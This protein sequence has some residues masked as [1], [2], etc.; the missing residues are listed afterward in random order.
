MQDVSNWPCSMI[1][2]CSLL[3]SHRHPHSEVHVA[4]SILVSQKSHPDHVR[5]V[6]SVDERILDHI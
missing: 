3:T 5:F 4:N 2:L 1:D 6:L